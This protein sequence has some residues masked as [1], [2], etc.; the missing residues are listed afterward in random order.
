MFSSVK[1]YI[2]TVLHMLQANM[3]YLTVFHKHTETKRRMDDRLHSLQ[4]QTFVHGTA[5]VGLCPG[6]YQHYYRKWKQ[7]L[8]N[9]SSSCPHGVIRTK[10]LYRI[11]SWK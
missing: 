10:T 1:A 3:D 11:D 8:E 5:E 4:S 2:T 7:Y 6:Y 9:I